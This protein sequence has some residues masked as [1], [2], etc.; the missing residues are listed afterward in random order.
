MLLISLL[1]KEQRA[2]PS[3]F[4]QAA[5]QGILSNLMPKLV[6]DTSKKLQASVPNEH[7]KEILNK[8][9][10]NFIQEHTKMIIHHHQMADVSLNIYKPVNV[11]SS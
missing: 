3:S 8:I 4:Q 2:G 6:T 11:I 5:G 10:A 9:L 7:S 1:F